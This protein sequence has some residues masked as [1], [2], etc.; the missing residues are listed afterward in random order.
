MAVDDLVAVSASI[1]RRKPNKDAPSSNRA[2]VL[3]A[4]DPLIRFVQDL[5]RIEKLWSGRRDSKPRSRVATMLF[6]LLRLRAN[7]IKTRGCRIS[8]V[9]PSFPILLPEDRILQEIGI[10]GIT[11]FREFGSKPAK[12][13]ATSSKAWL[14]RKNLEQQTI[15]PRGHLVLW[16]AQT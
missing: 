6:S 15:E 2:S 5:Q 14:F 3:K 12:S 11:P 13:V 7:L 16:R 9:C 4:K 1:E 10:T 8:R